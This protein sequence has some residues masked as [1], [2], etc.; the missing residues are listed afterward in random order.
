MYMYMY[1]AHP[2]I[3]LVIHYA[4]SYHM[5]SIFVG[6]TFRQFGQGL[7]IDIIIFTFYGTY[8]DDAVVHSEMI[9]NFPK[10]LSDENM[11]YALHS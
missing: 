11:V 4:K 9:L 8:V 2:L 5:L 3:I 6:E 1:N 10:V 7:L